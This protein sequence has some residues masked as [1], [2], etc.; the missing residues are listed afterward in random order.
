[1]AK[2]SQVQENKK[3]FRSYEHQGSKFDVHTWWTNQVKLLKQ[4]CTTY[5][6]RVACGP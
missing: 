2:K 3:S 6:P 5:G 1:M 4:A